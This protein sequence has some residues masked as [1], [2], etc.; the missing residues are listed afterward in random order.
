[1]G[2]TLSELSKE[3]K[4]I[5]LDNYVNKKQGLQTAGKE[6]G[7]SQFTVERL[8]KEYNIKKRSYTE[9]KQALRKYFVNDDFFKTQTPDMAYLLGF[10]AADGSV[11][12]EENGIFIQLNEKDEELLEKI[13]KR[14]DSNHPIKHYLTNAGNPTA[15]LSIWSS[16]WKKD[17]NVYN[18]TPQ[19]TFT[20]QPPTFL[21]KE[22]YIDYIHG[23]FD[24]DGCLYYNAEKYNR[25]FE[26]VGVSKPVLDWIYEVM[27]NNYG[28]IT[29]PVS[30]YTKDNGV[31]VYKYAA[32]GAEKIRKIYELFYAP[33]KLLF[34]DRK[35]KLFEEL[36]HE[37]L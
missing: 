10:I 11:S 15:K 28:I 30:H 25:N 23:Y 22:Y 29:T 27:T 18:I 14:V 37:T 7:A 6:F 33:D 36:L 32:R 4:E 13:R 24:G 26:I 20:L 9:A 34:L 12:K 2:R 19:K 31:I 21:K 1:M 35:K 17:L 16:E 8:L 3:Q 5:I